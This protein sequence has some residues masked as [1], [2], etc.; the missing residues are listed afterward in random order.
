MRRILIAASPLLC[1]LAVTFAVPVWLSLSLNGDAVYPRFFAFALTVNLAAFAARYAHSMRLQLVIWRL[2]TAGFAVYALVIVA[3]IVLVPFQAYRAWINAGVKPS[4]TIPMIL[5]VSYL[6]FSSFAGVI[7]HRKG[8]LRG[9]AA[10]FLGFLP[11]TVLLHNQW[12]YALCA[13]LAACAALP[14]L[15]MTDRRFTPPFALFVMTLFT[16]AAVFSAFVYSANR[17]TRGWLSGYV[18]RPSVMKNL[19]RIFPES[20]EIAFFGG[21]GMNESGSILGGE[22]AYSE[23]P[24]LKLSTKTDRAR[25]IYL[26]TR[27]CDRYLGTGWDNSPELLDGFAGRSLPRK[28][29]RRDLDIEVVADYFPAVPYPLSFAEISSKSVSATNAYI[30]SASTGFLLTIPFLKGDHVYV[31]MLDEGEVSFERGGAHFET[32]FRR[33]ELSARQ[34]K[35]YLALTRKDRLRALALPLV[36]ADGDAGTVFNIVDFLAAR[37][38]FSLKTEAPEEGGDIAEKFLFADKKGYSVHFSTAL[39]LLARSCGIPARYVEGVMVYYPAREASVE[40]TPMNSHSWAEVYLADSGWVRVEPVAF[41]ARRFGGGDDPWRNASYEKDPLTEKQLALLSGKKTSEKD[42]EIADMLKELLSGRTVFV[43]S[44]IFFACVLAAAVRFSLHALASRRPRAVRRVSRRL[45][46]IAG[47]A[48]ACGVPSPDRIGWEKWG[49]LSKEHAADRGAVERIVEL[50][51]KGLYSG[52]GFS[53]DDLR[54][55]DGLGRACSF[56]YDRKKR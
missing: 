25:R 55:L 26:S 45:R 51:Q 15:R 36:S 22:P 39:V 40:I 18:L 10:A 5:A 52:K 34:R 16:A 32:E 6:F 33:E 24:L 3:M 41:L 43:L 37:C 27:I 2:I 53:K 49:V 1:S 7:C 13:V 4:G 31:R 46:R 48:S 30:G 28:R 56:R 44:V 54:E 9:A 29:I 21:Y 42:R 14:A 47:R 38:E 23:L 11:F 35:L 12:I 20:R 19:I 17:D 8:F 50:A